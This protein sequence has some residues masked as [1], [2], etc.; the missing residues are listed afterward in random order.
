[1]TNGTIA[2]TTPIPVGAVIA[3]TT[4]GDPGDSITINVYGAGATL[5]Y[6]VVNSADATRNA[7]TVTVY[8]KIF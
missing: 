5:Y 1:V 7:N 8:Y 4:S 6:K 3:L 2:L